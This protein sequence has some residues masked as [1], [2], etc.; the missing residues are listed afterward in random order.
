MADVTFKVRIEATVSAAQA[1]ALAP[2][3]RRLV[4]KLVRGS[5]VRFETEPVAETKSFTMGE[6]AAMDVESV[7]RLGDEQR[8]GLVDVRIPDFDREAFEAAFN[9]N[10]AFVEAAGRPDIT[11]YRFVRRHLPDAP[12]LRQGA[13]GPSR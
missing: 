5:V 1:E 3:I 12:C 10:V 8:A 6:L 2:E 4:H 13:A 7:W 9:A 11:L